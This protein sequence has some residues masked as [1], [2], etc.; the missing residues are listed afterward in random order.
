MDYIIINQTT[1]D[2][3]DWKTWVLLLGIFFLV[4]MCGGCNGCGGSNDSSNGMRICERCGKS[5]E[6]TFEDDKWCKSCYDSH[7]RD[8]NRKYEE[9]EK[10]QRVRFVN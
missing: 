3:K 7:S 9:R 8:F 5:Y 4:K 2:M 6:P 10:A 1:K